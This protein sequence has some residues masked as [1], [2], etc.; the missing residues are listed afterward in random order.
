MES[1]RM[2]HVEGEQVDNFQINQAKDLLLD[3]K[4]LLS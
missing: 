3:W 1:Y 2:G 4:H